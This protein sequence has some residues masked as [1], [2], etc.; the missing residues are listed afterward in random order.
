MDIHIYAHFGG[1]THLA[2]EFVLSPSFVVQRGEVKLSVTLTVMCVFS[3]SIVE[4]PA[5]REW[6][7]YPGN[8]LKEPDLVHPVPV[9][10][11]CTVPAGF[12]IY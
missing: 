2:V 6:F 1:N 11:P 4:P 5:I 7:V 8:P 9:S 10:L 3:D 12:S